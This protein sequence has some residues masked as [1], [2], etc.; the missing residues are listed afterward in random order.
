MLETG[1]ADKAVI[2]LPDIPGGADGFELA[3]KFCYGIHFDLTPENAATVRCVAEYLDMT[4]K[5]SANNLVQ[6]T[7]CYINEVALKTLPA[8]VSTLHDC[9]NFMSLAEKVKLV[10]R[11]IDAIAYLSCKECEGKV[12]MGSDPHQVVEWWA[13]DLTELRVDIFQRVLVAMMS[14]GFRPVSLGP[15]LT[16]YAQK[17]LC[18]LVTFAPNH[19]INILLTLAVSLSYVFGFLELQ[20]TYGTGARKIEPELAQE[21]RAVVETVTSLL[22]REKNAVSASFISMLLRASILI[23][24]TMACRVNLERRMGLQLDR[25]VLDDLLIPTYSSTDDTLFDVDILQRIVTYHLEFE[26]QGTS[27][28]DKERI[29]TLLESCVAEMASDPHLSVNKFVSLAGIIPENYK[30]MMDDGMYRAVDIYLKANPGLS[31]SEKRRVCGI[32]NC[33]KLS[34][35]ACAHAAQNERLPVQ[36]VVQ[37]LFHEQQRLHSLVS[38]KLV[39]QETESRKISDC[40]CSTDNLPM[41]L[42]IESLKRENG[43][44]K[45]EN[46]KLKKRLEDMEKRDLCKSSG[47]GS[48][49]LRNCTTESPEKPSS[50]RRKSFINSMSKRLGWFYPFVPIGPTP[51]IGNVMHGNAKAC[52]RP[53]RARRH[54]LS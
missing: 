32:M 15:I 50:L 39:F 23:E 46:L 45:L 12:V 48:S 30:L 27:V 26:V 20:D 34:I 14:R 43:A 7:E 16:L 41:A 6:R 49:P 35:E 9:E 10:S 47:S 33:Q 22:P 44:L 31:D 53:R 19:I 4:E 8:A 51:A 18:C 38:D 37:V 3:A 54:S 2:L 36:F 52:S 25:A 13:E 42:E 28:G 40:E 5:Y 24:T 1:D 11:C 21:K 17:S 29:G